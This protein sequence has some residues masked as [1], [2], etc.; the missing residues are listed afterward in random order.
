MSH[1]PESRAS[2]ASSPMP[3]WQKSLCRWADRIAV[4]HLTVRF[5]GGQERHF[6]GAERGPA[7]TIRLNNAQPVRRLLS[8]GALGFSRAYLDGDW[9]TPDL[10]AVLELVVA[11][12]QVWRPVTLAGPLRA[13]VAFLQHRL[14]RNSRAGSRRNIAFHYDLGNEFY[15][16]WLDET[17]TYSSAL[18]T[19]P[20]MTLADAQREKYRRILSALNIGPDDHVLEI[21]CG[22]GGF[23]EYAIRETG[24]RVTGLTLS[25][26]QAAFARERL[27]REGLADRADIR[28]EDY[29]DCSGSFDKIVS[30]E[31]FEAVGEENWP[32]YFDRVRALLAAGGEALIQTITIAEDRFANYRRNADF[33]Q[34]YIFPGGMLPSVRAFQEGAT[35]AGLA[36]DDEFRFGQ[37]YAR[38]LVAWDREF[39]TNWA[40]IARLG[41]DQRFF[42]MW[43]YYLHY[44]AV[45][46]RTGR[47]DV[48]QF[49][50]LRP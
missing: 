40:V 33:I 12:D 29:R 11:N 48:V 16:L 21:G 43:H 38:T 22:W 35:A 20:D 14:R 45:G 44:C 30:I 18:Y 37:D 10:G 8:G 17:M 25:R 13:A 32:V 39:C 28:L 50:L 5:P 41:F 24:C 46:F 49:K 1:I 23:A 36:V 47:I 26:E 19:Q 27:Q 7:A 3:M 4:G 42:R 31:M 2:F 6:A 9:E 15:R 34:T